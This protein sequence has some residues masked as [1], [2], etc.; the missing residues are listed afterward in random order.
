MQIGALIGYKLD[1]QGK[2]NVMLA[3]KSPH[4]GFTEGPGGC[5]TWQL[6][7]ACLCALQQLRAQLQRCC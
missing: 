4:V 3:L 7:Q 5:W 6:Y 2:A 1:K